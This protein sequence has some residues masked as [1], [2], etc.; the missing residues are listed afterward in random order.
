MANKVQL[1]WGGGVNAQAPAHLIPQDAVQTAVNVDFSLERGGLAVRRGFT[2]FFSSPYE[3][4]GIHKRYAVSI[5]N[6][7]VYTVYKDLLAGTLGV[8]RGTNIGGFV[9]VVNGGFTTQFVGM[10]DYKDSTY[11]AAAPMYIKDNG[12]NATDWIKQSPPS[13]TITIN[14]ATVVAVGNGNWTISEGSASSLTGTFTGTVDPTTFRL[15]ALVS[16]IGSP[17][18][19]S[20]NGSFP[21]NNSGVHYVNIGFSDPTKV[22]RV[23]YDFS[24][25]DST[26][27]NYYHGEYLPSVDGNLPA[28]PDAE[29]LIEAGN[30]GNELSRRTASAHFRRAVDAPVTQISAAATTLGGLAIDRTKMVFVGSFEPSGGVD[31]WALIYAVR[32]V[33]EANEASEIIT[34]RSPRIA[35]DDGHSLNDINQGYS[36]WDTWA[37]IDSNGFVVGESAPSP[38]TGRFFCQ[39][40]NA[41][42][43]NTGTA[44]GSHGITHRITYRQGGYLAD[45]YAVSTVTYATQT[46]TDT[47]TDIAALELNNV[48]LRDIY[49]KSDIPG[50]IGVMAAEPWLDRMFIAH[51]NIIMWSLPGRPDA[52]PKASQEY[53]SHSG[54]NVQ[55]IIVWAPGIVI[56][57]RDSVSEMRGSVLEGNNRD[58]IIARS[59]ARRGSIAP[60]TIIKTP[61]GI[62][63]L[64]YDGLSIYVPGQ[65]IDSNLD[66]ITEQ[67]GDAFRGIN[68]TDPAALKGNRVPAVNGNI[69]NAAAAY[70]EGKLYL[71]LPTGTNT[72]NDTLFVLDFTQKKVWWYQYLVHVNDVYWDFLNNS[73]LCAS[74]SGLYQLESGVTDLSQGIPWSVKTRAWTSPTDAIVENLA[75]EYTGGPIK[76]VA[77]LDST[78]TRTLGTFTSSVKQ[79]SIPTFGGPIENSV[80]L[81]LSGT[82]SNYTVLY[83]AAWDTLDQPAKVSYYRSEYFDNNYPGDKLWDEMYIDVA[84][85]N[86][87]DTFIAGTITAVTFI[88]NIAAMTN[89]IIAN[90]T[91]TDRLTYTFCFPSETYGSIAYT[92]YTSTSSVLFKLWGERYSARNEPPRVTYWRTDIQSLD[93][94]I[95]DAFDVDINP[96][97]GTATGVCYVDNTAVGTGYFSNAKRQSFTT[98]LPNET[99]GRTVY[100]IYTAPTPFKHFNTWFHQRKEPDRWTNFVSSRVTGAE[101]HFD[102]WECDINPLGNIVLA[103]AMVDGVP[104]G[105]FTMTGTVRQDFVRAFLADSYGRTVWTRYN[106]QAGGRFKYFGEEFHGTPEPP[107]L[108]SVQEILPPYSADHYLKS[109]LVEMNPLGS[110]VTGTLL[111]DGN[112]YGTNQFTGTIRQSYVTG[113]DVNQSLAVQ[114]GTSLEVRY[115]SSYGLFKHYQT[116]ME[117]DAKPF[118]KLTWVLAYKKI[119]GTSQLDLA[120]FYSLDVDPGPA[121]ATITSI[122]DLEGYPGFTTNTFVV[123]TRTM[124]DRIVFPPGARS[125]LFQQRIVSTNPIKIWSSSLDTERVGIKGLARISV[126]GT[127][128]NHPYEA[129]RFA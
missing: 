91:A 106:V 19:L 76:A 68:A 103:T 32:V 98:A 83:G 87:S 67:M 99:Y 95:C 122:W 1:T 18:D 101:R 65:G 102:Y 21:I 30:I 89:T 8:G 24:V 55:N 96:L 114:S 51:D 85:L 2:Q 9:T 105:T 88:D 27:S 78:N 40:A 56:V 72:I 64:N 116:R 42:V 50:D 34:L 54:D 39:H 126:P 22:I 16:G 84:L 53:I 75:I 20:T 120:R 80:T 92:T 36:W 48:M 44:T 10:G 107:R 127:P 38:A 17:T 115:N 111:V 112:I 71:A 11:I 93:E 52:F 3:H 37:T 113:L 100:A 31:P 13:P 97:G 121:T 79:Y 5:V 26:F 59:G 47:V 118:G 123:S 109:W 74:F 63:L 15:T 69:T 14:V 60:M 58:Y 110:I 104:V 70:N 66:W 73:L 46:N 49:S 28:L 82:S 4:F 23:S 61:H 7:Q 125:R 62:P 90:S 81:Q 45:A 33:V 35:G 129:F 25:G 41:T 108:S 77:I 6:S 12:T 43:V 86:S 57:N 128:Q 119:G 29:L 124:I 94:N 117:T